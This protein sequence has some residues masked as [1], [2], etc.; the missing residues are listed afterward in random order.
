MFS[1]Y[2]N[3]LHL[4]QYF[5]VSRN[6]IYRQS[7]TQNPDGSQLSMQRSSLHLPVFLFLWFRFSQHQSTPAAALSLLHV[8]TPQ[9]L[10]QSQSSS[11]KSS[12]VQM[13]SN[14]VIQI[15]KNSSS[16]NQNLTNIFCNHR[17]LVLQSESS[18]GHFINVAMNEAEKRES[19][20]QNRWQM[21]VR[22]D[23]IS[24][25]ICYI[26]PIRQHP[27][28]TPGW[29]IVLFLFLSWGTLWVCFYQW[30][31]TTVIFQLK[32]TIL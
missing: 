4:P 19:S 24:F 13:S 6:E 17:V 32:I 28:G 21:L 26:N 20:S 18:F 27:D 2:C 8:P 16:S 9:I 3:Y 14:T 25:Q 30:E 5:C 10:N 7:W 12:F 31:K 15:A 11:E 22:T 23:F 1:L 29:P